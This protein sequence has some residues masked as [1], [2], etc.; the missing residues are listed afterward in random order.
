MEDHIK[1]KN[2]IDKIKSKKSVAA[3]T[4][5]ASM[6]PAAAFA[7]TAKIQ[8]GIDAAVTDQNNTDIN[9]VFQNV[10]NILLFIVGAASVIMLIVGGIRY[11]VS[12]G[13]QQ[14]V[15]NAKN[16]ILYAIVGIVI[17]LFAFAIVNFVITE[18]GGP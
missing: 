6:S 15:A 13:D 10:V 11:V 2:M 9:V 4:G 14:A 8:E 16:T 18:F 1:E 3:A 7:Q 17:A 5:V 12:A